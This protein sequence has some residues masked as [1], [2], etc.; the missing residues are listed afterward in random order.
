MAA[1]RRRR[2]IA[3]SVVI[4]LGVLIVG[5][6]PASAHTVSGQGSSDFRSRVLSVSPSVAGLRVRSVELGSRIELTWTGPDQLVVVGYDREPYLRIGPDGVFRNRRS[7]ASYLNQTRYG[8]ATSVPPDADPKANPEWVRIGSGRT[9]LWHDHRTQW[10][11]GPLPADVRGAPGQLHTVFPWTFQLL[12]S[13]RPIAVNGVLEWVPSASSRP[14]VGLILALCLVGPL[15][16]MTRRWAGALL[17]LT[18]LVV[19]ADVVHAVGTGL[20]YVGSPAHRILLVLG[21]SYYSIVAWALGAVGI[22]LLARRSLDGLFAAVFAGLVIGLF[23]GLTDLGTLV[24]SQ[25]PFAFGVTTARLLVAVSIG[26]AAG[27]IGGAVVAFR[28]NRA[29]DGVATDTPSDTASRSDVAG[30]EA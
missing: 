6:A 14:W 24:H 8:T 23:G 12:E 29:S 3:V 28:R 5:A 17:G 25:V 4:A 16:A 20:A 7:P 19:V 22:R 15:T 13:G 27:V 18:G 26:G 21:G 30:A 11:G 10:M 1:V 2:H 9:A